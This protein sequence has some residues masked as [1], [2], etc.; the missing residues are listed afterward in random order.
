MAYGDDDMPVVEGLTETSPEGMSLP[1]RLTALLAQRPGA[2]NGAMS[3]ALAALEEGYQKEP[4]PKLRAR[5]AAAR[6]LL[7]DGPCEHDD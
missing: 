4:N 7:L 1:S 3:R 6:S 5:I 2:A